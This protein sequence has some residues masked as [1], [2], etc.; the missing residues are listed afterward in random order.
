MA[1]RVGVVGMRRGMS[2]AQVFAVMPDCDVVACCDLDPS[3]GA[4]CHEMFPAAGFS[5]D[6]TEMLGHGLDIVVVATPIPLHAEHTIA[7][8]EAGCHVLQEVT[9]SDTIEGC[10]AIHD[11]V[12]AHPRQKFMLAENCC[13]WAY[14]LAW[15]LMWDKGLLGEFLYAEAEYVHNIR[16]LLRNADGT[17]TW[18][19]SR[20]PIIY[21]THSLGPILKV[22]GE[23]CVSAT[24]I[25]G[26][27]KMDS[28]LGTPDFMVALLQTSSGGAIK[29]LRAGSFAREPAYHSYSV[30]GTRGCLETSKPPVTPI[31]T[32][33]WFNDLPHLASMV[34]IPVRDNAIGVPGEAFAGGHGTIEY[35]MI[36]D[37]MR[38]LRAD[39]PSPIDIHAALDMTLPGLCALD[40]VRN[41]GAPV[42]I[43][44]WR[45]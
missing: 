11:A 37:F 18:R 35:L 30:Q 5:T 23:R 43:P 28:D 21:C 26:G 41:G 24:C 2:L 38:S 29:L 36:Q 8:L 4:P 27:S 25:G 17:P 20:P 31:R 45:T 42:S 10:R 33:A 39:A 22:T 12:K 34:E 15:K 14:I 32:N 3:F 40:S 19:A 44:N 16:T 13:Y 1:Y 9:L 6:Y 7:A